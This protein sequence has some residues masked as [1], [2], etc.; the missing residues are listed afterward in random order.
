MDKLADEKKI[1]KNT[2]GAA[3]SINDKSNSAKI[4][5]DGFIR[6]VAAGTE[7]YS[8]R[9]RKIA[10]DLIAAGKSKNPARR[11]KTKPNYSG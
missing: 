1:V 2:I 8:G 10:R 9:A 3:P 4:T 6:Q 11:L 7:Y 5:P